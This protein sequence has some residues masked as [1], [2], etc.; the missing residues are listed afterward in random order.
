ML[1][2][3]ASLWEE[4][5]RSVRKESSEESEQGFELIFPR[6]NHK[7][8]E[9]GLLSFKCFKP[10]YPPAS[11]N[12]AIEKAKDMIEENAILPN[13]QINTIKEEPR[14]RLITDYREYPNQEAKR[15]VWT[16]RIVPYKKKRRYRRQN[17]N[18]EKRR[19]NS[20]RNH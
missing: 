9:R 7:V 18:P 20:R 1:R 6:V 11:E 2:K 8:K 13:A 5:S 17:K 3:A 15:E 4:L 10:S 16:T 19:R 12:R 14:Q